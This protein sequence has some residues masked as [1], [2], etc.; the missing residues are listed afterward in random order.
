MIARDSELY[1]LLC[2]KRK[3]EGKEREEGKKAQSRFAEF[4]CLENFV[5]VSLTQRFLSSIAP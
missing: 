2:W 4:F 3:K 5:L 1:N